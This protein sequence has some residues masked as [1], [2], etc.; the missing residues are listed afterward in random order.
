MSRKPAAAAVVATV[1][2]RQYLTFLL[3]GEPFGIGIL[4]IKEILEYVA[5]TAVPMMPGWI[6]GV[7]NLRGAVVPV[8]DLSA[9]FGR[10]KVQVTR[11]TC[12]IIIEAGTPDEPHNVGILVDAVNTV[13]E[14]AT[15][16]IS[17]PPQFGTQ[18]RT[19]FIEGMGKLEGGFIILL[20]ANAALST[21]ELGE[22]SGL[23]GD[24]PP[25]ATAQ[26]AS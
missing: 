13:I 4:A 21:E 6:R 24:A 25:P 15:C 7:I 18:I 5:V 10:R 22:L 12:I 9:R 26:D 23:V 16:D 14:I 8:I 19:S 3:D 20:D 1:S 17:P 2:S 11:R